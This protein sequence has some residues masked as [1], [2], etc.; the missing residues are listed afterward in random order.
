MGKNET[1][2]EMLLREELNC[3]LEVIQSEAQIAIAKKDLA[4]VREE[5]LVY[6]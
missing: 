1:Y 2:Y 4:D 6:Q 3:L 5:L